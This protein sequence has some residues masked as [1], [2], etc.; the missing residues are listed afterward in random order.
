[1]RSFV[2][3]L[4]LLGAATPATLADPVTIQHTQTLDVA[5]AKQSLPMTITVDAPSAADLSLRVLGDLT[6]VQRVLPKQLSRV[7]EGKCTRTIR[8]TVTSVKAEGRDVRVRGKVNGKFRVCRKLL[9]KSFKTD[10]GSQS[11]DFD[12]LMTGRLDGRCLKLKSKSF[13][14][15]F[16]G[17]LG[18]VAG[19][20]A[21]KDVINAA[22]QTEIDRAL[23]KHNRCF[24]LPPELAA[25][26][27]TVT[28]GHFQD[29][30]QGKM[31]AVITGTV[32]PTAPNILALLKV[33]A[34][35][36]TLGN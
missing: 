21:L 15:K 23:K 35:K 17:L 14:A 13:K 19:S 28:G 33:L 29:L 18:E 24:D 4:A 22:V 20:A 30:G 36:G 25:L 34:D 1:M 6:A 12:A 26:N 3:A 16:S 31:G 5:G 10:L 32:E 27:A 9:G 11:A 7:I 2:I 8:L